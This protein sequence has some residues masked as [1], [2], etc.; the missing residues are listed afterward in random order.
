MDTSLFRVI[1]YRLRSRFPFSVSVLTTTGCV[2]R[3]PLSSRSRH[4]RCC[5]SPCPYYGLRCR[6]RARDRDLESPR[7]LDGARQDP[8][9]PVGEGLLETPVH[10]A[11]PFP[12]TLPQPRVVVRR[13]LAPLRSLAPPPPPR[14]HD[15]RPRC[16]RSDAVAAQHRPRLSPPH[17]NHR[18]PSSATRNAD[19]NAAR[20]A[21]ADRTT[22][23]TVTTTAP[24]TDS[25]THAD[26]N[27][28]TAGPLTARQPRSP[29]APLTAPP[30]ATPTATTTPHR[31][32]CP[33]RRR[34]HHTANHTTDRKPQYGESPNNPSPQQPS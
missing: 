11:A 13:S 24:L 10:H 29:T 5:C 8:L 25:I 23:R 9:P 18:P 30:T 31:F 3:V 33:R 7:R 27:A 2:S 20:P 16:V 17:R 26:R 32:R 19:S 6:D 1:T 12:P 34:Q 28:P 15:P 4:L 21:S 14:L 22:I